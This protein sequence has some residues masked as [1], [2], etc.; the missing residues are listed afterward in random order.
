MNLKLPQNLKYKKYNKRFIFGNQKGFALKSSSLLFKSSCGL[1]ALE[2]GALTVAQIKTCFSLLNKIMQLKKKSSKRLLCSLIIRSPIT[3]KSLGSRMG[4]GKG[5]VNA[6]ICYIKKG[7]V[8]FQVQGFR[9]LK[10]VIL[11]FRK[12]SYK[13]PILT[14]IVLKQRRFFKQ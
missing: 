7:R 4:R 12:L 1:V 11:A 13:L 14:K 2:S 6:W 8:L 9:R 10:L 5:T 3:F